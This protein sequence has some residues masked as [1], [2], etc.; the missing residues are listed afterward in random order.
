MA[1]RIAAFFSVYILIMFMLLMNV[2]TIATGDQL[3]ETADR[4][5]TYQL[6]VT[7][8]R[9]TIYDSNR[10]PLTGSEKQYVA[11]VTPT[12]EAAN[13]LTEALSSEEMAKIYPLMTQGK[14][15][16]LKLKEPVTAVGIDVFETEK[17]YLENQPAAS[18]IGYLDGAGE[19]VA[20]IEK[21]YQSYLSENGGEVS[22]LYRVDAMNRVLQGESKK[23][24]NTYDRKNSGVVLT[25]DKDIQAIA[26][27][28]ALGHLKKGAVVVTEVPSGAI[29]ALVSLP[30]YSPTDVA[31]ALNDPDSPMINRAFSAYNVGSVF[32]LVSAATALEQGVDPALTYECKGGIK[33]GGGVFHCNNGISHGKVDMQEAMAKSCNAYFAYLMQQVPNEAFLEMAQALGFGKSIVFAPGYSSAAG[34]LPTLK[35]LLIP[36]ALANFSFGQGSLLATPVQVSGLI[37]CIASRGLYEEPFLVEGLLDE[38]K[39]M[40]QVTKRAGPVQ[41]MSSSTA[42]LLRQF[43]GASVDHGTSKKGAPKLGKAGAK[44]G[45]AQ[46]GV[47][48][49]G[50]E[51][52]QLWFAGLYP[53]N[54]PKYSIVVLAEDGEG[55]GGSAAPVFQEICDALYART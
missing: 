26:E 41:V 47:I 28:A 12:I 50:R 55:G 19:G 39:S 31:A 21:A 6:T 54:N 27:Q 42:A 53:L 4:Q 20:G 33:I 22:I 38:N 2:Y 24:N 40:T 1:R 8:S 44:T 14:P 13:A 52:E 16:L 7:K 30:E 46:T 9:G 17:R 15:F 35:E 23:I 32:K 11:A 25:I 48:V 34:N 5:S 36:R 37:N 49:D 18:V 45:T 43:M 29:R 3:A 10:N 51:V